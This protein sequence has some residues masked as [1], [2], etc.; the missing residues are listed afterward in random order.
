[1]LNCVYYQLGNLVQQ[2]WSGYLHLKSFIFFFP[3]S[4]SVLRLHI[5]TATT[6]F[7]SGSSWSWW[8]L[9]SLEQL[10]SLQWSGKQQH[11]LPVALTTA[12]F[13][14]NVPHLQGRAQAHL[15][16]SDARRWKDQLEEI[17]MEEATH[18]SPSLKLNMKYRRWKCQVWKA[19]FLL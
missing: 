5:S 19:F 18:K 1:M 16:T 6:S 15:L 11:Y 8:L 3:I 9:V 7:C 13:D 10:P 4:P 14:L 12:A 17:T 2:C